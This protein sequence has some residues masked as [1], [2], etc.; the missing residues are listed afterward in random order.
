MLIY[1]LDPYTYDRKA[2]IEEYESC[3]WTERF[4]A[5]GDFSL[6]ISQYNP[7]I[8]LLRAGTVLENH[9]S[10]FPMI[11]EG[12]ERADG[13]ITFTGRSLETIF[14]ELA[15]EPRD[16]D[17]DTRWDAF[18]EGSPGDTL[19]HFVDALQFGEPTLNLPGFYV[20]TSVLD[21]ADDGSTVNYKVTQIEPGYDLLTRLAQRFNTDIYIK[22]VEDVDWEYN[23]P[24]TYMF[25]FGSRIP[26]DRSKTNG[27][28]GD[29]PLP[30]V[31]FSPKDD[32]FV[33][34]KE[35]YDATSDVTVMVVRRP[36]H[37]THGSTIGSGL[38]PVLY[39]YNSTVDHNDFLESLYD[40]GKPALEI[41]VKEADSSR[42]TLDYL[43]D[44]IWRYVEGYSP[45]DWH[46]LTFNQQKGILL[47]EMQRLAKAEFHKAQRARRHVIDGEVVAYTYEYGTDYKLGDKVDVTS[48]L[49]P[50]IPY[51][52]NEKIVTEYIRSVDETG[53][54]AY[55]TLGAP[56]EA[57]NYPSSSHEYAYH[58][59][60]YVDHTFSIN[61]VLPPGLGLLSPHK[62]RVKEGETKQLISVA[63]T[64][65]T[66]GTCSLRFKV[67]GDGFT[68]PLTL[69]DGD[70]ITID[71]SIHSSDAANVSGHFTIR[72]KD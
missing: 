31:R 13:S 42:L 53:T 10:Q 7:H 29:A 71:A 49:T 68:M 67:N 6:T 35:A 38:A 40:V 24:G 16:T 25:A 9:Q 47:A 65:P 50:H 11:I 26:L 51:T 12:V 1:I 36:E 58:G 44:Q 39:G 32:N 41:R 15:I 66:A 23:G 61:G 14:S 59:S 64:G 62:V 27:D 22:R 70:L 46:F 43:K 8:K 17:G 33:D 3:I 52:V 56:S 37:F 45:N 72:V 28:N 2:V 19:A 30:S 69:A 57:E 5:A 34:V 48:D 54:R 55:P 18:F 20:S 4:I 21:Q 60:T 63:Q